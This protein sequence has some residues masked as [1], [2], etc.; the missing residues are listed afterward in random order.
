MIVFTFSGMGFVELYADK[1][2]GSFQGI[3]STFSADYGKKMSKGRFLDLPV[4]IP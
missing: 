4:F 1:L 3:R 2:F